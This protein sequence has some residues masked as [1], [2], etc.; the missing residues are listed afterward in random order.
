MNKQKQ[1]LKYAHRE[2][3]INIG[4]RAGFSLLSRGKGKFSTLV[5]NLM[6]TKFAQQRKKPAVR[7]FAGLTGRPTDDPTPVETAQEPVQVLH[8]MIGPPLDGP[9]PDPFA[10]RIPLPSLASLSIEEKEKLNK[11]KRAT[12]ARDRRKRQRQQI[13]AIKEKLKTPIREIKRAAQEQSKLDEHGRALSSMNRGRWM[14]DAPTGLGELVVAGGSKQMEFIASAHDRAA[15]LGSL[16]SDPRTGE[17]FWAD[18][19]RRHVEPQGSGTDESD[20]DSGSFHVRLGDGV[21]D[22]KAHEHN[23]RLEAL[24]ER[25]F[26]KVQVPW[27]AEVFGNEFFSCVSCRVQQSRTTS[28]QKCAR[29]GTQNDKDNGELHVCRLCGTECDSF[30]AAKQHIYRVHGSENRPKHDHRYGDVTR[31]RKHLVTA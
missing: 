11:E 4:I 31:K 28:I 17:A 18:N 7:A 12:A 5:R 20:E 22:Q 29:C 13:A 27:S 3:M 24:V 9:A 19:D 8:R 15:A 2:R 25:Y 30:V 23:L 26:V 6:P 21:Q 10:D 14:T 16:T 1:K